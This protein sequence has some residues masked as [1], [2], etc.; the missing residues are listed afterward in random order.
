MSEQK[1]VLELEM[2]LIRHGESR[3]NV[4]LT[5]EAAPFD[6]REDPPL[7]V[8]GQLQADLLGQS[9][10]GVDFD[11]VYSSAMRRAVMTAKGVLDHQPGRKPLRLLPLLTEQGVSDDY[12]GQTVE[13]LQSLCPGCRMAEGFET[14]RRI[15]GTP[16]RPDD[17]VLAR[18]KT[19][20][21]YLRERHGGGQKIAVV[22]HAAF[23]TYF[24]FRIC[25]ITQTM[26]AFDIDLNNTGLTRVKF[27]QPGTNP[28]GDTV[29]AYI[30]NTSHL[31]AMNGGKAKV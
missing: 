12:E 18:A 31:S 9:L 29:F 26:P 14:A 8:K 4:G 15:N 24:I 2:Y 3:G 16:D 5:G 6:L 27:Y 11:A 20:I 1:P 23:L 28:F 10:A 13:A 7:T 22:S 25:G 19:A 21:D 17:V 30:N